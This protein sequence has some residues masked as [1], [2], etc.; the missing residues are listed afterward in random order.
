MG[1]FAFSA[2]II[3]S[4]EPELLV[5]AESQQK[6]KREKAGVKRCKKRKEKKVVQTM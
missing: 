5:R 2:R 3:L 1:L 4:L 6:K